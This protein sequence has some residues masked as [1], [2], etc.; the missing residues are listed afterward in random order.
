VSSGLAGRA[1]KTRLS[2]VDLVDWLSLF[3]GDWI[4][5]T[6]KKKPHAVMGSIEKDKKRPQ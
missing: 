2:T 3:F 6:A 5:G 1:Q 4:V